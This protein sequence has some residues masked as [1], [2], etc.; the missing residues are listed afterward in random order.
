MTQ[1]QA[2][3]VPTFSVLQSNL[4]SAYFHG[5]YTVTLPPDTR[6]PLA[7]YLSI[8]ARTSGWID[9]LIQARNKVVAR[10]GLKDMGGLN[11]ALAPTRF[12]H[13]NHK[14]SMIKISIL[15]PNIPGSRFNLSYY[16]DVEPVIQVSEVLIA[17]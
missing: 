10:L 12:I 8:V 6:S 4:P 5:C 3:A 1:A 15:Y 16:T 9:F 11:S 2:S 14:A 13:S 7:R 17:C